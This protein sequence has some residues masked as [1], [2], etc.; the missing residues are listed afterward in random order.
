MELRHLKYF[1]TIA[2]EGSVS[3][4]A[5]RL[6]ISQPA[7]SRQ[8]KDLEEELNVPLFRRSSQG[9]TLT[10][11]G[12]TALLHARDILRRAN[13]LINAVKPV[14]A[15]HSKVLKV[16]YIPTALTGF[17]A[18]G[19]RKF[20]HSHT[21][22][23]VQIREMNPSQQEAAL[24][25]GEL[26]LALLGSPCPELMQEF[27]TTP[28][29]KVAM[30]IVLPDDHL[31]A[32]RKSID[33]KELADETFVSLNERDFPGRPELLAELSDKGGFP[34]KVGV[35]ADGLSEALGMVAGG[36]GIAILPE[37]VANMPHPGV[38]FVKMKSPR[39]YLESSAAW[40][41]HNPEPEVIELVEMLKS[42]TG[43]KNK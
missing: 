43:K 40:K 34:I 4:A 10:E 31:L 27:S 9:L 35:K 14:A 2:E 13:A 26:D 39:I 15:T 6:N 17:L 41:K 22:T 24:R 11:S 29:L 18:D 30:S 8:L 12:E 3:R 20:N 36:A 23:C 21:T 5:A 7:I 33:L 28:I 37:D 16:G 32:L 19:M 25:M 1:V 38:V 42:V